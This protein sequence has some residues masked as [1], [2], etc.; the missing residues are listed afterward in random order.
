MKIYSAN[1]LD[2]LVN[3]ILSS[4]LTTV[5]SPPHCSDVHHRPRQS[6]LFKASQLL[7]EKLTI[8]TFQRKTDRP[9]FQFDSPAAVSLLTK[10]NSHIIVSQWTRYQPLISTYINKQHCHN[11]HH[12]RHHCH[13]HLGQFVSSAY[14][15]I[16]TSPNRNGQWSPGPSVLRNF[17]TGFCKIPGSRNYSGQD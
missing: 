1:S 9:T 4:S 10:S 16:D 8:I 15:L 13:C 5:T 17:R 12:H 11:C 7:P 14:W 3:Q 6:S 2:V